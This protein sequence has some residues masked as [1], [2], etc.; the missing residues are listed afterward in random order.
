MKGIIEGIS[1]FAKFC[2]ECKIPY[3]YQEYSAGV[4]NFNDNWL[5]SLGICD[6]I[7]KHLQVHNAVSRTVEAIENWLQLRP[8]QLPRGQMMNAYLHFEALSDHDYG[9]SFSE[10]QLPDPESDAPADEV[11]A[12]KYWQQVLKNPLEIKPSYKFWAPYIGPKCR[13]GRKLFNTEYMKA[14]HKQNLTSAGATSDECS[15]EKL[16]DLFCEG[17]VPVIR[18]M[19]RSL[20]VSD[21]GSKL[22]IINRIKS[23]LNIEETFL[24]LFSKMWG[25]SGGW[26]GMTCP[27]GVCYGL[28]WLLRQEGPRDHVDMLMNLCCSECYHIGYG[29]HDCSSCKEQR[30]R[31]FHPFQGRVAEYSLENIRRANSGELEIDWP[32]F[33]NGERCDLS[34]VV[35]RSDGEQLLCNPSTRSSDHYCLFDQFHE[36]NSTN[37]ADC[38]RRV[39]CVNQLAGKINSETAEQLNNRRNRD[40]YFTTSLTAHNSVFMERLATHFSNEKLNQRIINTHRKQFGMAMSF[41]SFGQLISRNEDDGT[42]QASQPKRVR[43][44]TESLSTANRPATSSTGTLNDACDEL[45]HVAEKMNPS[46]TSSYDLVI[47]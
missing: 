7:R 33:P 10:L 39:S 46:A 18:E 23:V 11:D 45:T 27:H 5:L 22:G 41:N 12:E 16:M 28:K 20:N 19:A 34:T 4:H 35:Q 8:F 42:E 38:L 24:K 25:R 40:N 29:K 26:L 14:Y 1:L 43:L 3:R 15:I 2:V 47:D 6:M 44:S 36:K 17:K 30:I 37:P 31:R 21:K 9:F 32:W 13:R